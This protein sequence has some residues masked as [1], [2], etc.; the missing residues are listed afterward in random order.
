[1]ERER[2]GEEGEGNLEGRGREREREREIERDKE[3]LMFSKLSS[4]SLC[5]IGH[6]IFL[7]LPPKYRDPIYYYLTWIR[8][9]LA[10]NPWFV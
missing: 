10:F 2:I 4:I 1:M 7:F 9:V 8:A 6:L 3:R 5:D